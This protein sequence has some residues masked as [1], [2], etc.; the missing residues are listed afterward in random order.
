MKECTVSPKK[1]DP[2]IQTIQ[3]PTSFALTLQVTA[4]FSHSMAVDQLVQD[5]LEMLEAIFSDELTHSSDGTTTLLQMACNPRTA[6]DTA[7]CAAL[8]EIRLP[9]GYP[10]ARPTCHIERTSCLSDADTAR[11]AEIL[12]TTMN[13]LY[14]GDDAR[15]EACCYQLI[16]AV[17]EYLDGV[18]LQGDCL[19]CLMPL[20]PPGR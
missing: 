17:Q 7:F 4:N 18:N 1:K 2:K 16:E 12:E 20:F 8:L 19:I 13:E 9:S 3:T 5:E 14:S 15:E 6:G 11:L 10:S